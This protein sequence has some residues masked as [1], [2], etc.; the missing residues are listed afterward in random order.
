VRAY[1]PGNPPWSSSER[2]TIYGVQLMKVSH[3][4]ALDQGQCV[5]LSGDAPVY[6]VTLHGDFPVNSW[7]TSGALRGTPP[8]TAVV[9][10][11]VQM[12]FDAHTGN[13]VATNS[14]AG[15]TGQ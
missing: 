3:A 14:D 6:L 8:P 9:S 7:P 2:V 11:V 10:H 5:G 1:L 15:A 4:A 12:V 13:L